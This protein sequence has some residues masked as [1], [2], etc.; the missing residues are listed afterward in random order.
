MYCRSTHSL[1]M[2]CEVPAGRFGD[3]VEGRFVRPQLSSFLMEY[4]ILI[5]F[6]KEKFCDIKVSLFWTI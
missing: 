6:A 3:E 5:T 1:V 4:Y 2:I